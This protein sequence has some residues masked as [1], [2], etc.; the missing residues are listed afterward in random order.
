MAILTRFFV[1]TLIMP[2]LGKNPIRI[3]VNGKKINSKSTINVLGVVFDTKLHWT[4]HITK[5]ILKQV[6][7]LEFVLLIGSTLALGCRGP[8]IK[9]QQVK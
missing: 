6:K 8:F 5:V 3:F 1:Q 7:L 9:S 2:T 4:D